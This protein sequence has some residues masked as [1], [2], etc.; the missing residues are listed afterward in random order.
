MESLS[1]RLGS[2]L[3][4]LLVQA[5][6]LISEGTEPQISEM[7]CPRA[8]NKLVAESTTDSQFTAL[9]TTPN[10]LSIHIELWKEILTEPNE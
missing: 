8:Q 1:V 10:C 6:H 5:F 9:S 3:G 2:K 4:D 7:T